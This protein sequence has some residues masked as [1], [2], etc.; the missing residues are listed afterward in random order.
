MGD[1]KLRVIAAELFSRVRKDLTI[2]RVLRER[3]S[4]TICAPTHFSGINQ[5]AD[6]LTSTPPL[7]LP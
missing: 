4:A 7:A 3:A 2:E 5:R 1:V 6:H